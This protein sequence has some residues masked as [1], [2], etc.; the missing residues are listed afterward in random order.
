[1]SA[2]LL[3]E[4]FCEELPPK[5]L[6]RLGEAFGEGVVS[7]LAKR[8]MVPSSVSWRWFATPR[9]LA[10][11][12]SDVK[13]HSEPRSIEVKL[14]PASVGLDAYGKPTAAL[15]KKL[16][17][18]G[19]A[20]IDTARLTK[21]VEGKAEMLFADAKTPAVPLSQALQGALDEAISGL[22]I[23]KVMSYQLADGETTVRFV[24][25]AHG[26]VALH[27]HDVVPV[28]A[29]GLESGRI[30]HGHR[31]QG[32]RDVPL[33]DGADYEAQLR[34][35]GG[36]IAD[37]AQRRADIVA[38]L[39][40]RAKASN[41]TLGPAQA[42]EALL[43][44]VT[45]LVEMPTVYVGTFE[46]DFLAV[47]SECLA[48]TMRQNQKYFPLF[49]AAGKLTNRFLI[50]SN[51]RVDDPAEIVRGNERVVRARLADARFF[52]ETDKKVK[53][54]DR[55]PQL[56]SIV[57]QNKLGTLFDRVERLRRLAARIQ[58]MLPR[59]E[60]GRPY[61]DRAALLAKADLATLM[62]GEFPELQGV[63]GKYYA[64]ADGEEPSIVR[65]IEQHYWPRFSGDRLPV[66]DVS[67]AVALADKLE[68]IVG[69]FGI[70]QQPTGDKDPLALRRHAIGIVRILIE[71]DF[72]LPLHQLVAHAFDVFP[73]GMLGG[74]HADVESFL[75]ER[76]RGYL[77]E[78]GYSANEVEAVLCMDPVRLSPI[79]KQLA[80]IRDFMKLPEAE[81]LAAA[82]KRVA[83]ILRQAAAKG[84]AFGNADAG[85]LVEQAELDLF[86]DLSTASRAAKPLFDK[87]DYSGYLSAFAML[88]EPVDRFFDQVMVMVD[89]ANLR[90]NRLALLSDLRG[91]MNRVADVSKLAA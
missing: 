53:L 11:M 45:A 84:E 6:K 71:G 73:A 91:E 90:R 3:V 43:D 86:R 5:A 63:M 74:A 27:G 39:D 75:R 66:G 14:M 28:K 67:V 87:G 12:V 76:L 7:G 40:A 16:E 62:V 80:A 70:G 56:A 29:L 85:A 33:A 23:P 61:A 57:Y 38:Q 52:F 49:D 77:R 17:S 24:R 10:V 2:T 19:L 8:E 37:F 79:P 18:S 68:A 46:A 78:Q 25:P 35:K 13:A 65:A 59:G 21:R 26:L 72:D 48:L 31:F 50:V 36:V 55:V 32:A 22:P 9:R 42:Y 60:K 30:T 82:N 89:D 51:L 47:P 69:M 64:E 88:K 81:S 58:S 44:E 4:I 54:A 34:T 41:S 20:G 83:N 1:M 15:L